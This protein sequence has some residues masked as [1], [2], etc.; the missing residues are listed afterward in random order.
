MAGSPVQAVA[1]VVKV[2]KGWE[3][4]EKLPDGSDKGFN[5]KGPLASNRGESEDTGLG[6]TP[7]C[8]QFWSLRCW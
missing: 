6:K 3:K 4:R 2:R 7:G 8:V 1:V 5:L